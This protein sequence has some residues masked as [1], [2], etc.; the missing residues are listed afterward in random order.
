MRTLLRPI[1]A[2]A[3]AGLLVASATMANAAPPRRAYAA[4]FDGVWSV[5]IVTLR[6][7]C[8]RGY[9]YPLRIFG[10]RVMKADSDPNY[11]VYGAVARSGAIAVTVS[12]GGKTASGRGRLRGNQGGGVWRTT[13]GQCSGQWSAERRG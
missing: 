11:Q 5:L 6:G 10:G 8:D 9:R 7:D 1:Y 3:L 13:S 12:G 2:V 4:S